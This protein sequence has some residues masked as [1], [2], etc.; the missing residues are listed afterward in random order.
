MWPMRCGKPWIGICSPMLRG[1]GM[2]GHASVRGGSSPGLPAR[3][4]R[5]RA[6]A[7]P[8]GETWRL[9]GT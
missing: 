7:T 3:A 9:V 1:A 5:T 4:G 2:A 6:K 8:V